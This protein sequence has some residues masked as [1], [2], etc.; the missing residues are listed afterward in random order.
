MSFD[1]QDKFEGI[2]KYIKYILIMILLIIVL[3]IM[4][5]CKTSYNGLEKK[6][7]EATLSYINK[8]SINV[9]GEKYIELS[10]LGEIEGTELCKKSSG[11]IV[12]NDNGNLKVTVYLKCDNY[13][14]KIIKNSSKYIEL[15]G[16][17]VIILNKGEVFNDPLYVLKKEAEVKINGGVGT[18]PGVY[19]ITYFVYVKSELKDSLKRIVIVS[20]NDKDSTISGIMNP[21]MPVITLLGDKE[22]I[23]NKGEK[24]VEPGY[25]AVDYKDGKIS[26]DVKVEGKVNNKVVG[27]YQLVYSVTNSK[28]V[29]AKEIRTVKVVEKKGDID[30]KLTTE[31]SELAKSVTINVRVDGKDYESMKLPDGTVWYLRDAT[32][33]ATA[34][35]IYKFRIYDRYKNEYI[36]EIEINTIDNIPPSGTCNAVV[37][38]SKTSIEVTASDNKG[39]AGY[40]YTIDGSKLNYISSNK[41]EANKKAE[42]VSVDI[43]DITDNVTTIEC[44]VEK[45]G[46]ISSGQCNSNDAY[47][48]ISTCFNGNIIKSSVPL[49]EYLIGVLYGEEDPALTDSEDYIKTFLIFARTYTLNRSGYFNGKNN[50]LRSCSNDQNWCDPE[51]GCYRNQTQEMFDSCVNFSLNTT[52]S[53]GSKPY[54]GNSTAQ[55]CADRVTTFPGSSNVSNRSFTINNS[56]W[57]SNLTK[58]ATSKNITSRWK[59]SLDKTR[60]EFYKK[61]VE[62]TA[63]LIIK[64]ANG[65]PANVNYEMCPSTTK[66]YTLCPDTAEKLA[67]QG[68]TA[69]E[70]IKAY[71]TKYPNATVGC[72]K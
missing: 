60:Y 18:E 5:S 8:N 33:K 17:E 28:G 27:T 66:E 7:E 47:I 38:S 69:E 22:M 20:K 72:Y 30:I 14:S 43:K 1:F 34:N 44:N 39:I 2:K 65:N 54:Y 37:T 70:L 4:K 55:T 29:T 46:I 11:A 48:N 23:I 6:V 63:G 13:E 57:P 32:Y 21:N 36:K 25:R 10:E 3:L 49:E 9:V 26:R 15:N 52:N 42:K 50:S 16:A 40:S 31:S 68:Y 12:K 67:N 58:Q 53:S 61:M 51:K 35:T 19:T 59:S 64:D 45:K 56:S 71:T 62:E 24:Y 41:Y